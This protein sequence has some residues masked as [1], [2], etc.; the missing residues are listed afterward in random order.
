MEET[1]PK[2]FVFVLMP[3]SEE[4]DDIYKVG[5]KAACKDIGAYCERVD[6]QNFDESILEQIRNQIAK[7]DI[8]VAEMSGRNANVFYETGYA[9][10][11]N[12]R[13]ILVTKD[14]QDIP[15]DLSIYP[16]IIHKGKI[17]SLKSDLENRLRW[18]IAHPKDSL[19]KADINL[20][21]LVNG[22][23]ITNNPE[24]KV[25]LRE[26]KDE[27]SGSYNAIIDLSVG[28]HNPSTNVLSP[29]SFHLALILPNIL[30][31]QASI[32]EYTTFRSVTPLPDGRSL[33]NVKTLDT[34]FPESWDTLDMQLSSHGKYLT[35]DKA[36][37]IIRFF[38]ELKPKDYPFTLRF[39]KSELTKT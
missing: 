12:K 13:V 4:F 39:A 32:Y 30:Y 26:Y 21:F 37:L 22:V 9:H 24:I 10:A 25:Q 35:E 38:T 29:N 31:A 34:L 6:E 23:S 15:F 33:Y 20:E 5:I 19:S 36:E 1:T 7:A 8:I 16:H 28:V 3:F 11:L 14:A 17:A 27:G 2:P 18:C